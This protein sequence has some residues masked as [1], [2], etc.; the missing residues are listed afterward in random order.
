M[1]ELTLFAL[2]VYIWGFI[3]VLRH[4][5]LP[6]SGE[7]IAKSLT[8]AGIGVEG[9]ALLRALNATA[10]MTPVVLLAEAGLRVAGLSSAPAWLLLALY[11]QWVYALHVT[12]TPGRQSQVYTVTIVLLSAGLLGEIVQFID[13][14]RA[15]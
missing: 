1:T 7:R 8:G 6:R 4:P 3:R 14:M 13:L 11:A 10:F 2:S 12:P 5:E 9:R 15:Q